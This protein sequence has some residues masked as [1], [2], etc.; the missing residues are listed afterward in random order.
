MKHNLG[1]VI[2]GRAACFILI[3]LA[4]APT[5][6]G[7]S[8]TG[9]VGLQLESVSG[10]L[11]QNTPKTLAEVRDFGFKY[12]EL[13]GD[14]NQTPETLKTTLRSNS[15]TAV[16]A[17]FPYAKY[18]DDPEGVA[19]EAKALGLSYA[20][21]PSLPQRDALDEKG[22]REAIAVF[23]RAGAAMAKQGI[24]FFY[25]PHG[26]EFKPFGKGTYFDLMAAEMKPEWVHF[27]MDVFWIVHAGQDP[28]KLLEKYRDRWVSMHLKDMKKGTATG[29]FTGHSDKGS[30]VPLGRGQIDMPAVLRT[31]NEIGIKWYFI[32]DESAMP[33]TQIP[34]SMTY[35]RTVKW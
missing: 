21:C 18:R 17:H 20:G 28:V 24:V 32:E 7:G 31:A 25:H 8:F 26:Y 33:E 15:L 29:G 4:F 1:I 22:C 10:L 19:K 34:Q 5:T 12:V 9:N 6:F 27:Q 2:R 35:L 16:S 13:V 30:F 14:Y 11:K 23:N 3:T